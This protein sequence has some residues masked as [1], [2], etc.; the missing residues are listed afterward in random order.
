MIRTRSSK[1]KETLETVTTTPQQRQ[2][3]APTSTT[4]GEDENNRQERRPKKKQP[5]RQQPKIKL[6]QR[7]LWRKWRPLERR[8]GKRSGVGGLL[9][10][11]GRRTM[12][13]DKNFAP[14]RSMEGKVCYILCAILNTFLR[15]LLSLKARASLPIRGPL[16]HVK[17]RAN[18]KPL[19][20]RY[21]RNLS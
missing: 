2:L 12:A 8:N 7:Q 10:R 1:S 6:P 20:W 17:F 18:F 4:S 9:I 14:R 13:I 11:N 15:L 5:K 16:G 3:E 21:L 19:L